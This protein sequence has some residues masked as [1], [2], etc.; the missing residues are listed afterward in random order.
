VRGVT[1]ANALAKI[2]AVTLLLVLV[3]CAA[4]DRTKASATLAC[5]ASIER[6]LQSRPPSGLPVPDKAAWSQ[7]SEEDSRRFL[8][9][10]AGREGLDCPTSPSGGPPLDSWGNPIY[11]VKF[12]PTPTGQ[13]QFRIASM[14]PDGA[15]G[16]GDDVYFGDDGSTHGLK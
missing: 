11:L 4:W 9:A 3:G 15:R 1:T 10:I 13:L 14:G 12:G 16:T 8:T 2:G 6:A 5:I 7:V